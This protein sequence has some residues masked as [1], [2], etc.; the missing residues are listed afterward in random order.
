LRTGEDRIHLPFNLDRILL[1]A[2]RFVND[3]TRLSS[4]N[5]ADV[6]TGVHDLLDRL[7][8]HPGCKLEDEITA[9]LN[10]NAKKMLRYYILENLC[11]KRLIQ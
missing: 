1:N 10:Q 7:S 3:K 6:L 8:M 2:R 5:P 9:E 4:L 11:C